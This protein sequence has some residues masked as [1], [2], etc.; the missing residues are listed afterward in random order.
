VAYDFLKGKNNFQCGIEITHN[1]SKKQIELNLFFLNIPIAEYGIGLSD[2][3]KQKNLFIIDNK[4]SNKFRLSFD[5]DKLKDYD[6]LTIYNIENYYDNLFTYDLKFLGLY[7]TNREPS[8]INKNDEENK[9]EPEDIEKVFEKLEKETKIDDDTDSKDYT[10]DN[11]DEN[12]FKA[13]L[14]QWSKSQI[15]ENKKIENK[16]KDEEKIDLNKIDEVCKN[17][18]EAV[19]SDDID[20]DIKTQ[21]EIFEARNAKVEQ[22]NKKYIPSLKVNNEING[23]K[24]TKQV[25]Y[26]YFRS[27][28]PFEPVI[29]NHEW[30]VN[31]DN[32]K[33]F[34][35]DLNGHLI[36]YK[37]LYFNFGTTYKKQGYP[38]RI[39]GYYSKDNSKEIDYIVLG[40][41][42]EYKQNHQPMRGLTGYVYWHNVEK[43]SEIGY[44]VIYLEYAT[45]KIV[46]PLNK[47]K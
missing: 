4:K 45:G 17:K 2:G 15:D 29:K 39:I 35:V 32:T 37:T 11:N 1:E 8:D 18:E 41:L 9:N 26:E 12:R 23:I 6:K 21:K 13:L 14:P 33:T 31:V 46:V 10:E 27:I 24:I 34:L 7:Q 44:W 36:D 42:G 38:Q 30:F 47:K 40:V 43:D 20:K 3:K 25:F 5:A 28:A 19:K 16:G 22:L